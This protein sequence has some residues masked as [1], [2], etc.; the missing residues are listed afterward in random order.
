MDKKLILI[1]VTII[2]LM[3]AFLCGYSLDRKEQ[4][5]IVNLSKSEKL[6]DVKR[7]IT[8][9]ID[10]IE[11][12]NGIGEINGWAVVNDVDSID[13]K[14]SI[15]LRDKNDNLYKIKTRIIQRRDVTKLL[16]DKNNVYDNSGITS[17]FNID[18]L[19]QKHKYQIGIQIQIKNIKYFVWTNNEFSL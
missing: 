2:C 18:E 19:P 14:P 16:Q 8:Y 7:E 10:S 15:I 13:V 9:N 17:E 11:F 3:A 4:M 6:C 5:K 1:V 12:Q